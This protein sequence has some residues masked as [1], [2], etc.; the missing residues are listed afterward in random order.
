MHNVNDKTG[1]LKGIRVLELGH[2]MAGPTCGRILADLG[3]EVIKL[4]RLE[5]EDSRK[6]APPWRG[7]EAAG[8]LELNRNKRGIAV[9]LKDQR[10]QEL[11][12]RMAEQCDIVIENFRKGTLDRLGIGYADLRE[13]NEGIILCEIS[14]FGRSGPYSDQGG[15]DVVAQAMSGIMSV[16]GEGPG[17]PPVKAGVAVADIGAGVYG[18]VGIL[19]ALIAR[20]KTGKGQKVD[21]SLFEVA[22]SFMTWPMAS[23]GA[24]GSIAEPMGTAHPLDAPYQAF[25]ASDNWFIVGAANQAN[26]LRLV[27]AIGAAELGHDPRF[28][29]NPDRV[30][31]YTA[32]VE[33]LSEIFATRTADAW[34]SVLKESEIPTGPINTIKE[35]VDDEHLKQRGMIRKVNHTELGEM[36]TLGLPIQFSDTPC[37]FNKGAPMLGE[38][39]AEIMKEF[40]YTDSEISLYAAEDV[41]GV[42][43]EVT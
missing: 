42:L 41:I 15:Y 2:V 37:R 22:T 29:T 17:R 23:Y 31:N 30:E 26:W 19:S 28:R 43:S 25:K 32:L 27:D 5:G 35:V 4:E 10:G 11:V 36:L 40:G 1:P 6:M 39:T 13:R 20:Q 16:T 12:L 38:H 24:D 14:G 7:N 18:V 9:N 3:A 21:T 8:F 34:I 33:T